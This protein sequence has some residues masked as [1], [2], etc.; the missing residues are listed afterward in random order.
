M[1][2]KKFDKKLALNKSTVARLDNHVM[3]GARGGDFTDGTCG[4][5]YPN[6][7]CWGCP[8]LICP[9]IRTAEC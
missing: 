4:S 2:R 7:Y 6:T 1:K 3:D 9:D 5:C 8:T